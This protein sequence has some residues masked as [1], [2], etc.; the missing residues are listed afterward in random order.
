[1]L[2]AERTSRRDTEREWIGKGIPQYCLK[3]NA[4]HRESAANKRAKEDPRE[5]RHHEDLAIRTHA[6][7]DVS[8]CDPSRADPWRDEQNDETKHRTWAHNSRQPTVQANRAT[9][10]A[11]YPRLATSPATTRTT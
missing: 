4:C 10:S 3:Q 9:R 5:A 2:L 6:G 1:M 11:T 7:N 8:P